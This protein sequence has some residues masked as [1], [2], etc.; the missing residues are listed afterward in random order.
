VEDIARLLRHL[1]EVTAEIQSLKH[2]I[3]YLEEHRIELRAEIIKLTQ[4]VQKD[5]QLLYYPEGFAEK[6]NPAT[7]SARRVDA[8]SL[9]QAADAVAQMGGEVDALSLSKKI[10]ISFDAARL[11]LARATKQG[12]L[13]RVKLGKYRAAISSGERNGASRSLEPKSTA[14]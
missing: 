13:V 8:L 9:R 10:G 12:L 6:K 4:P 3:A 11:R 1:E 5:F 2:R 14:T 7:F